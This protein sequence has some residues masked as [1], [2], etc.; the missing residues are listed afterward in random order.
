MPQ[1]VVIT[2]T[3]SGTGNMKV[4]VRGQRISKSGITSALNTASQLVEQGTYD[5]E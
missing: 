4:D 1:S 5:Q 3:V 2:I